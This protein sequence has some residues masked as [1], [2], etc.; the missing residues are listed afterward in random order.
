M[1]CGWR[2]EGAYKPVLGSEQKTTDTKHTKLYTGNKG[3]IFRVDSDSQEVQEYDRE[4][5]DS[6]RKEL[7]CFF[8]SSYVSVIFSLSDIYSLI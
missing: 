5:G 8:T 7:K 6:Q 2:S 3:S 4:H 1:G